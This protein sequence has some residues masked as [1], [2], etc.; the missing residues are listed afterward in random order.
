MS[1]EIL[2]SCSA[3]ETRAAIVANG[4]LEELHIERPGHRGHVG[5]V[6]KGRVTRVLPGMQAAFVD[7][8]LAR[9]A[10]LHASDIG[11]RT[12]VAKEDGHAPAPD[13]RRLLADGAE[14]LV[15]VVK[16][17]LGSKGARLTAAISLPS[18]LLVFMPSAHGIGVST[19]I[20]E[21]AERDRLKGELGNL[22][23]ETA[24]GGYIL[25]TAAEGVS[26]TALAAEI[27]MLQ[28]SWQRISERYKASQAPALLHGEL[29]L[30]KRVVR[31]ECSRGISRIRVD[32]PATQSDLI[33]FMAQ[34][35]P[36]A[37]VSVE[38]HAGGQTLFDEHG[39]E[40]QI[41]AAMQRRIELPSG[42]HAI[43]DQTEA[44]TT[45]DVNTG[46]YVGRSALEETIF[47]TNLEAATSIARQLR[48]RNIGG[49]I[50]I[51]FIDMS[52]EAH[53]DAVLE[54]LRGELANDRAQC[55]VTGFS[56]LGLV[57]MTRKRTRESLEQILC[58]SCPSCQGRGFVRSVE[59]V[60]HEVFREI[61][62]QARHSAS[63]QLVILAAGPVVDGLEGA[64]SGNLAAL[65]AA[66]G[67]AVRVQTGSGFGPEQFEIVSP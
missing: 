57:E 20:C 6:Y 49:I 61:V 31:D 38:L 64:F 34:L 16:D 52:D 53:R 44:M 3:G 19:R 54:A 40:A 47:R 2:I 26:D 50:V 42:G 62:R 21:D 32:D 22:L 30:P 13:I 1:L 48:L 37:Q 25:R 10:F 56:V 28:R 65:T 33:D 14:L 66:T 46:A 29:A 36:Q 7:I 59:S 45:V 24:S 18:R 15:Q 9:T 17:P 4:F 51:D 23:G 39:I 27:A 12:A 8:G 67:C 35:M 11:P 55:F 5:N 41:A 43:I 58:E 63:R 60:C